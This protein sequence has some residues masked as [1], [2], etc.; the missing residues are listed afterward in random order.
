MFAA[1]SLALAGQAL[2]R[3]LRAYAY[4]VRGLRLL[5]PPVLCALARY[6]GVSV[7]YLL[8]ETDERTRSPAAKKL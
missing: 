3:T 1:L 7:D 4:F 5:P 2:L 8:G 6:Y